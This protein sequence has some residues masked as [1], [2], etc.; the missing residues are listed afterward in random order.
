MITCA[1]EGKG[2]KAEEFEYS[3]GHLILL[4]LRRL[5]FA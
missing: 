1:A 5:P 3:Q 4:H 2:Q